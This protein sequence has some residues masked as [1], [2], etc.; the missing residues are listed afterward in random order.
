M[1]TS[2]YLFVLILYTPVNNFSVMS[3]QIFLGRA[4][5]KQGKKCLD[6]GH[7]TVTPPAAS[8]ELTTRGSL[9]TEPPCSAKLNLKK[10]SAAN[11]EC[12]LPFV[13]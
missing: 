10:S 13:Y 12:A 2:I 11:F 8:L 5:A 9:P 3:G 4:S 6:Q 1:E 7:N